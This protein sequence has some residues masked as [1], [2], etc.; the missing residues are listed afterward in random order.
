MG[1][2][3]GILLND[4][5]EKREEVDDHRQRPLD[6]ITL[7]AFMAIHGVLGGQQILP[8][9]LS[10]LPSHKWQYPDPDDRNGSFLGVTPFWAGTYPRYNHIPTALT[11]SCLEHEASSYS[12]M[13]GKLSGSDFAV[14][15]LLIAEIQSP[16]ISVNEKQGLELV[17]IGRWGCDLLETVGCVAGL[18]GLGETHH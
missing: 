10:H 16:R 2:G 1:V 13:G 4:N 14:S 11:S 5:Q 18:I 8:F 3:H 6:F 15:S 7:K 12:R 17:D 9:S